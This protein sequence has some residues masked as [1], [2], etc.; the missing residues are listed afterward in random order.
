MNWP[1]FEPTAQVLIQG[2]T[3]KE[4]AR[5]AAW[6][7]ASGVNVVGGVTPGKG[8]QTVEGK[9]VFNS[10]GELRERFPDVA[11]SSIVVPA[12]R[13]PGAVEE[14]LGAGITSLH[15]LT[16]QVPVHDV[17]RMKELARARGATILGPSSVGYLQFPRFR[18][19]YLGG[20]APF[21]ALKEG[22][23]AIVSTSGGMTNELMMALSR[24]GIGVRLAFALGGDR[25]IGTTLEE[26]IRWSEARP[27]VT[28]LAIFIE[29]GRPLLPAL[30][31]GTFSFTKPTVMFL[32]GE[33]LD[34]LPRGM[35]YGHTGTILG[36]DERPVREIREALRQR[37]VTCVGTMSEF[38]A[39]CQRL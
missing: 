35:P 38:L 3:G 31:S 5:M 18:V 7:V 37:N 32:A 28:S 21:Q 33:A 39:A 25:V 17:M 34:D 8:G 11:V 24:E 23:M 36:E 2:I 13:V 12:A 9:P 1:W 30:I 20:E 19:G 4:G 26:A 22:G 10:V 16:E 6:L 29:P 15:I 14:A 27:E